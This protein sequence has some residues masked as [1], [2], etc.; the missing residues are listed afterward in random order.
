VIG[1]GVLLRDPEARGGGLE[2]VA[3]TPAAGE[4]G[5]VHH[6]V[7]GQHGGGVAMLACG[8]AEAVDH[9]GPLTA[10]WAVTD[11]A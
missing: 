8:F 11:R 1:A 2:L 5:G 9:G 10:R 6:G 3:A 7:V 4:A